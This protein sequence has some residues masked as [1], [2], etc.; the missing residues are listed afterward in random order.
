MLVFVDGG[1]VRMDDFT[2]ASIKVFVKAS[3]CVAYVNKLPACLARSNAHA[4][5]EGVRARRRAASSGTLVLRK[6]D[7]GAP[8]ATAATCCAC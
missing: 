6:G 5:R 3:C 7:S 8:V 2:K 4:L 1:G